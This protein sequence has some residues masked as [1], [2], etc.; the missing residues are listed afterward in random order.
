[1]PQIPLFGMSSQAG[2]EHNYFFALLPDVEM[3]QRLADS[4]DGL[5]SA[6]NLTGSWVASERYCLVLHQLGQ[7]PDVRIDLVNRAHAAANKIQAKSFDIQLDQFMSIESKT[8][9]FPGVLSS[10]VESPELASFWQLIKNNLI[11]VKLGQNLANSCKPQVTLLHSRQPLIESHLVP[12]ICWSVGDFVLIE[13]VVGKSE[14]I[15]LGRWPL[16]E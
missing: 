15:E 9:K 4:A 5:R 16:S 14:Y 12:P 7:F 13:S 8:G 2:H 11:A 1:M 10:S 6:R 3:R